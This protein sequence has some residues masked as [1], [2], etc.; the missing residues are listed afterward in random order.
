MTQDRERLSED[1]ERGAGP[2]GA[3]QDAE[4]GLGTSDC[5]GDENAPGSAATGGEGTARRTGEALS[6]GQSASRTGKRTGE[7]VSDIGTTDEMG[8]STGGLAGTSR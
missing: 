2:G 3:S 4:R 8:G 1:V 5:A 7:D 6:E